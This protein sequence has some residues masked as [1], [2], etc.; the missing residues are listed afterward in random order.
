MLTGLVPAAARVAE[1]FG[2]GTPGWL[3]PEE[4]AAVRGEHEVFH[5]RI[6]GPFSD[7]LPGRRVVQSDLVG[8]EH[9][10]GPAVRRQGGG[11][12]EREVA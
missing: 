3:F 7:R 5:R 6:D 8:P 1:A 4:E 9:G 2:D 10:N 11:V 12:G